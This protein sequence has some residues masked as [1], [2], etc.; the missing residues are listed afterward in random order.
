VSTIVILTGISSG[1]A[2]KLVNLGGDRSKLTGMA[3][4]ESGFDEANRI[5]G[6]QRIANTDL[7]A[8]REEL[9][10]AKLELG[11]LRK[12]SFH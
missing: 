12:S 11:R 10:Q 6:H 1:I 5:L 7:L 3:D 9:G 2:Q 8:L 4:L